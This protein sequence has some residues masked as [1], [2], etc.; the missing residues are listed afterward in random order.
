MGFRHRVTWKV[1]G[2]ALFAAFTTQLTIS[3]RATAEGVYHRGI[4]GDP[5]TL[6]P[7]KTSGTNESKVL[8]D[9][10]EGLVAH[11]AMGKLIPGV[12]QSWDVSGDGKTYTF[13]LRPNAKWSNGDPL[14]AADFVFSFRRL[15]TPET[16][17]R[18]A[19]LY[20]PILAAEKMHKRLGAGPD[21][22]GVE[23]SD[24]QTLMIRLERSTPYFLE[25]LALQAAYPLHP[26]NV[27]M[28]GSDFVRPGVL[29]SNGA[30]TL[31]E[32]IPNSHVVLKKNR[33]YYDADSVQIDAVYYHPVKDVTAGVRRFLAS[34]LHSVSDFPTDQYKSLRNK[35]GGQVSVAPSLGT[36]YLAFNT[37]K[38]PFSD[39]RIRNALSMVIDREF[40]SETIWSGTM[41]PAYSFIPPGIGNYGQ[42]AEAAYKTITLI[43]R[44][45]AARQLL[46]DAGYGPGLRAL[47][48]SLRYN[49]SDN[50]RRTMVAIADMWK[51][52]LGINT[53]IINSDTTAHFSH[54]RNGG[55]F[56]VAR[57]G[58]IADYSDPQN[59]LFLFQ[60]DNL[61]L[62]YSRYR[63]PEF[64]DLI[65]RAAD[66]TDLA[67]RAQLLHTADT[68]IARDVPYVPLL[69][70]AHR[71]LISTKLKGFYPNPVGANATRF[72]QLTP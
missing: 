29:I 52:A 55:D 57:G 23:A 41:L 5:E 19:S 61:G 67:V 33:E 69:F 27:R 47:N 39:S 11:D 56:D 8:R 49:E 40:L 35:L 71:N 13:H 32:N 26:G 31:F 58:W 14:Q 15:L 24:S 37:Q 70:Y 62:N 12:A 54:L 18:Y 42:P 1:L 6:D 2:L 43:E 3:S 20:Y 53:T 44:E 60:S 34:E 63:N 68:I 48:V 51:N 4:D 30:Y 65:R 45:E 22:L 66:Q 16:A 25:I 17:A 21:D 50:N 36:Y 10:F 38:Q 28:N 59:F 9:L 64:D 7:Q 72:M 46:R